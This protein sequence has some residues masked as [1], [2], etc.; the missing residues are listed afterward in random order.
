MD[1]IKERERGYFL[2]KAKSDGLVIGK[3]GGG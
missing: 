1:I 2:K 3:G